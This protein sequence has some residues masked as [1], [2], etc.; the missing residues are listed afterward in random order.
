MG[1][2]KAQHFW[3]PQQIINVKCY[4]HIDHMPSLTQIKCMQDESNK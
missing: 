1:K 2:L 4:P 3:K